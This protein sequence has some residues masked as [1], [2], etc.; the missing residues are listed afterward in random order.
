VSRQALAEEL[1]LRLESVAELVT[2]LETEGLVN[3]VARRAGVST[4]T[5]SRVLNDPAVVKSS[6]R[7]RVLKVIAELNYHPNLHARNLAGGKSRSIGMIASNLENP[8][9][10]DIFR[11][12]E[13]DAL[14]HGYEVIVAHTDYRPSQLVNSIRL[15]IGRRVAGLAVIVSEMDP[16]LIEELA[17]SGIPAV[18]YDVGAAKRN[19]SNIRVN[20]RRGIEQLVEYLH[21]LGHK[22]LA[23]VGHHSTL[24][25][26]SERER[27]FVETVSRY[28]R[29]TRWAT[30]CDQDGLEGG[31]QAARG[32]LESDLEPT[33][34]ICVN[35]LMAVGVLR[36]LRYRGLRVPEDVS[37]TGFDNI[38][39][40]EF[41]V[42]QLTTVHIPR[43]RI[44][45]LVFETLVPDSARVRRAG[46]EILIEPEVILRV[47]TGPAPRTEVRSVQ[48]W[49]EECSAGAREDSESR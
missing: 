31:H 1:D 2:R 42:P 10:F 32:V 29:E 27:A 47:S 23:F 28:G 25:P 15:M 40:S 21:A 45:H 22:R 46:R 33:A 24:G 35:D 26:T 38:K 34:I 16:E 7:A 17:G 19:I 36:E 37:V 11:T 14:A 5:V 4:A 13:V 39:L 18:F 8:F 6:T 49:P 20:Y 3:Q 43:D 30:V 9:F 44:G 48:S 12:L 41:S